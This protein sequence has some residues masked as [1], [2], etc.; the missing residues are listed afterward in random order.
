MVPQ[1]IL[2]HRRLPLSYSDLISIAG[3]WEGYRVA[4]TCSV[5]S[6]NQKRLEVE[7]VPQPRATML[8]GTCGGHCTKVHETTKRIVRDLPILD[9]Q[10]HLIVHRRRLLC[11]QCG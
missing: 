10:T 2:M 3:G 4:R 9:S 7:L 5:G 1:P 11:P 6:G 8:C